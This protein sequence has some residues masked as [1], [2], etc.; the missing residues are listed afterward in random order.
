MQIFDSHPGTE[1]AERC[2]NIDKY[3]QRALE[4]STR[5]VTLIYPIENTLPFK[6]KMNILHLYRGKQPVANLLQLV[7]SSRAG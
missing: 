5:Q 3:L 6:N 7:D 2:L 4:I 1:I